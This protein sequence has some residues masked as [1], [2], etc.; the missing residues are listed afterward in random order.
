[1]MT[2]SPST[3]A[4]YA[5]HAAE[6]QA[7]T[8]IR[9]PA[10]FIEVDASTLPRDAFL[11][12]MNLPCEDCPERTQQ[13]RDVRGDWPTFGTQPPP[14]LPYELRRKNPEDYNA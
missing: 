3:D 1:M 11:K 12:A 9:L 2:F 7:K 4:L 5:A 6:Q 8:E 14:P 10:G 13:W